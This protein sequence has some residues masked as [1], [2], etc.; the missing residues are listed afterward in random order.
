[1]FSSIVVR[2]RYSEDG[3]FTSLLYESCESTGRFEGAQSGAVVTSLVG[4]GITV[5]EASN[6]I[7]GHDGR[8]HNISTTIDKINR[9][10][11][12]VTG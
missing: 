11:Y 4:K 5:R 2:I 7:N 10:L 1:M 6:R 9:I 12:D 8:V 3:C